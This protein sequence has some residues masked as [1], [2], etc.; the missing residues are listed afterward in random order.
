MLGREAVTTD[1]ALAGKYRIERTIGSGAMGVVV[2]ARHVQLGQRVAIKYLVEDAFD[3]P[4][5]VE[6]FSR[7]ARAL[8]AIRSEH[9][10]RVH[11]IGMLASGL[12]Y[13]V[14]EYLEGADLEWYLSET[15]AL[16]Q[17]DAVRYVLEIC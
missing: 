11:D 1:P 4:D 8:A 6:R 2:A 12:P 13:M 3:Y 17:A 14:L 5:L 10:A 16:T 9:V 7:E 15:G